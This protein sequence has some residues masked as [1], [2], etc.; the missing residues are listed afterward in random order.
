MKKSS[1]GSCTE[2]TLNH[3]WRDYFDEKRRISCHSR[4][5]VFN[6][7]SYGT[8][9][10]VIFC[11]HGGGYSGLTWAPLVQELQQKIGSDFRVL[12]PDLR[13]HGDTETSDD[14]NLSIETLVDDITAIWCSIFEGFNDSGKETRL[15]L[16]GH[17]AGGAIAVRTALKESIS[18]YL[19]GLIVIDVVEGTAMQ[20]L[21]KMLFVLAQRPTAFETVEKAVEWAIESGMCKRRTSAE[22]S[23]PS[24]LKQVSCSLGED[25]RGT[26]DEESSSPILPSVSRHGISSRPPKYP[27]ASGLVTIGEEDDGQGSRKGSLGRDTRTNS[28]IQW[29]WRTP[30]ADSSKYWHGWFEGLSSA[31]LQVSCPKILVLAGTDRLDTPLMIAQMQGKFQLLVVG[32]AGHAVHEDEPGQV[33]QVLC[34]FFNR[35]KILDM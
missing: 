19:A 34:N 33:A 24:M 18:H 2:S 8:K 14:N 9:G 21:D 4:R 35:F 32:K 25:G 28:S 22:I 13:C 17:S 16:V 30:L 6:V 20:S 3:S 23:V 27:I 1:G 7:Y 15:V 10:P 31:F 29:T 5:A 11:I 12:A 26:G